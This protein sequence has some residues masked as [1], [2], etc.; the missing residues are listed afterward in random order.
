M[1]SGIVAVYGR[2]NAGK[3]TLVNQCLGFKLL[4]VSSKPQTTRDNVRAIYNDDECQIV[5]TDSPGVF[6][7]HGKLGSILLRD[8]ESAKDGADVIA[9]VVDAKEVPDFSLAEKLREEKT[10]ILLCYNKIDLVHADIGEERLS[11]YLQALPEGTKVIRMSAKDGYGVDD[12]LKAVKAL[13]PEGDPIYPEDMVS[14]HPQSFIVGEMVREKCLRL[15][16]AE[17]PHSIYIDVR[18]I[19]ETEESMTVY[20]DIIVEKESEKAIVIGRAGA[21]IGKIRQYSEQAVHSYFGK[22]AYV[23]LHVKC[24]PDWRNSDRYLRKFGYEE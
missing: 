19:E 23:D 20:A 18:Q 6:R 24:I 13:L 22:K 12:F 14:D 16:K 1:K 10:P 9:Y 21:M 15:L 8:A 2:A 7:P 17:V 5:F 4:P 3:S 11:R